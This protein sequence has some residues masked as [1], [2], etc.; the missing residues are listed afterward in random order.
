MNSMISSFEAACIWAGLDHR[1]QWWSRRDHITRYLVKASRFDTGLD[2]QLSQH[3]FHKLVFR[4]DDR[5]A[6]MQ[7]FKENNIQS[8]V[9]YDRPVHQHQWFL[10][11][12]PVS[13]DLAL[14]SFT[15]PNQHTLTDSEVERIAEV[16]S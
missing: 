1:D 14:K 12:C 3:T 5:P 4:S 9:H 8:M 7:E 10:G 15:V 13:A 11:D 6:I 2:L 16:L